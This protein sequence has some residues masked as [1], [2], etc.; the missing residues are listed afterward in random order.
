[1]KAVGFLSQLISSVLGGAVGG[2]FVLFGVNA[3][4]DR[5]SRAALRALIIEVDS[6]AIIALQMT[7]GTA[8]RQNAG[9]FPQL[10][11]DPGWLKSSI[12]DSQLPFLV[13]ALNPDALRLASD[14][15]GSLAPISRMF[16]RFPDKPQANWV[17]GPSVDECLFRIERSFR[18]T[19]EA[20]HSLERTLDSEQW[21]RRIRTTFE[22]F[23]RKVSGR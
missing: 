22:N 3:Q 20:L 2:S 15:Y 4:F 10:G 14:A 21:K 19:S 12:W 9:A 17:V 7:Q 23:K 6:N 1:L 11:P 18:S 8:E 5:Q 13:Q 16:Y